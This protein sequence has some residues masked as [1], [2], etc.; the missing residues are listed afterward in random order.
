MNSCRCA[1]K[2]LIWLLMISLQMVDDQVRT[3]QAD[4]ERTAV[5]R[6][7]IIQR[8]IDAYTRCASPAFP[9]I[10]SSWGS[11]VRSAHSLHQRSY[12]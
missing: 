2:L 11:S 10:W 4:L 8:Q 3:V 9:V 1:G 12:E 6:T 7:I 5:D